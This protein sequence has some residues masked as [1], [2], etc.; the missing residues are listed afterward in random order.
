MNLLI[1]SISFL[2]KLWASLM[3]NN[4]IKTNKDNLTSVFPIYTLLSFLP[5]CVALANA[6]NSVWKRSRQSGYPCLA[7]VLNGLFLGFT[8]RI[9][10]AMGLVYHYSFTV[11]K[12]VPSSSTLS[13]T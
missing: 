3:S 6:L 4:S 7:P 2:V 5:Y 9:M 12:D 8:F 1:I 13:R 11:F 10:M